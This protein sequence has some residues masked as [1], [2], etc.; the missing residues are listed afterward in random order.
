MRLVQKGENGLLTQVSVYMFVEL[1]GPF[2][3]RIH[4]KNA[5]YFSFLVQ[6]VFG[7]VSVRDS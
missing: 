2:C 7:R 1:N 4:Q 5:V 3:C 6:V